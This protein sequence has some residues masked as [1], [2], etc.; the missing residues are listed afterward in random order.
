MVSQQVA[1]SQDNTYVQTQMGPFASRQLE[2]C[3]VNE[4]HEFSFQQIVHTCRYDNLT[5]QFSTNV[6]DVFMDLIYSIW[7]MNVNRARELSQIVRICG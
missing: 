7:D 5:F 2:N 1:M 3:R 4:D 6:S